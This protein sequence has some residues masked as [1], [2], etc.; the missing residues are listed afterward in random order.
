MVSTHL[1]HLSSLKL[2]PRTPDLRLHR[3][4]HQPGYVPL[5]LPAQQRDRADPAVWTIKNKSGG[6]PVGVLPNVPQGTV[7]PDIA[8]QGKR[9]HPYGRDDLCV[10]IQGGQA[11]S[12]SLVQM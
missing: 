4:K 9:I 10:T 6:T 2:T 5:F 1:Y 7:Y 3:R 12:G 11:T 8:G